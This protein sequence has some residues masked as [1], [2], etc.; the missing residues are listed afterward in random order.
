MIVGGF[1]CDNIA[2]NGLQKTRPTCEMHDDRHDDV[3][4][5]TIFQE[6]VY[7]SLQHTTRNMPDA[8]TIILP[9]GVAIKSGNTFGKVGSDFQNLR[10]GSI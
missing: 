10:L 9:T 3:F 1:L 5:V 6:W 7:N 8:L 2:R 4:F